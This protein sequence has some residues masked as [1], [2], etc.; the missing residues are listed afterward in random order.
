[1][2]TSPDH[3]LF[4][5]VEKILGEVARIESRELLNSGKP[6]SGRGYFYAETP[7]DNHAIARNFN[8]Y[9]VPPPPGR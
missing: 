8:Q 6:K 4:F 2:E 7:A 5:L 9:G 1:M 3:P